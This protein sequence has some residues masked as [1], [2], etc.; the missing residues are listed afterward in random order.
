MYHSINFYYGEIGSGLGKNTWNDW[1]LI[2]SSRPVFNPPSRKTKT[3]EIPGG[4]GLLDLS[5]SLTG[6]PLFNNREGSFDF[7]VANGY[8]NWISVYSKILNYLHGRRLKA[9]LEDEPNHYYDGVFTVNE[10]KSNSDGTWSNITIDYS[11]LPYKYEPYMDLVIDNNLAAITNFDVSDNIG[12]APT[13]PRFMVYSPTGIKVTYTNNLTNVTN[14]VLLGNGETECP[15]MIFIPTP[16]N[17]III[18]T[19]GTG[20]FGMYVRKGEL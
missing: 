8:E 14:E 16:T 20:L 9:V 18:K 7:I 19:E 1:H 17:K 15:D 4:H 11:V 10:W 6:Y 5:E 12:Y 3:V 2:P 13:H